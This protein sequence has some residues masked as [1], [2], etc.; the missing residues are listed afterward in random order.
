[1]KK[2][3][4]IYTALTLLFCAAYSTIRAEDM[5]DTLNKFYAGLADIIKSNM[6]T[7]GKCVKEV[8]D[9]YKANAITVKKIQAFTEKAM[10]QAMAI[11]D[12]YG[13][14]VT[15]EPGDMGVLDA[16]ESVS[17]AA[18]IT[19]GSKEYV[20]ALQ[21]FTMRHPKEGMAIASQVVQFMPDKEKK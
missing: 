7:P 9:Y 18:S 16:E 1:M 15:E 12:K 11:K 8:E 4:I 6:G 17:E 13:A 10:E 3:A 21:N 19:L 14:V 5:S 2:F 20:K